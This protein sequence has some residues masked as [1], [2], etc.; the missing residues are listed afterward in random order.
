M[1]LNSEPQRE[2]RWNPIGGGENGARGAAGAREVAQARAR[3]R[4]GS[5]SPSTTPTMPTLARAVCTQGEDKVAH[6]VGATFPSATL[7][8]AAA[9]AH[10]ARSS[11]DTGD[12]QVW[13]QWHAGCESDGFWCA[14]SVIFCRARAVAM[15]R[16]HGVAHASVQ[17]ARRQQFQRMMYQSIEIRAVTTAGKHSAGCMR[18]VSSLCFLCVVGRARTRNSIAE[19]DRGGREKVLLN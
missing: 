1:G 4:L 5:G 9:G 16:S 13:R 18:E 19:H 14:L 15:C 10:I 12:T 2:R 7:G 17:R 6:T 3:G 8:L 11:P